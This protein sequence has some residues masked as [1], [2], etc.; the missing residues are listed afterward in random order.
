MADNLRI[1]GKPLQT[2]FQHVNGSTCLACP[3]RKRPILRLIAAKFSHKQPAAS[4]HTETLTA[5]HALTGRS[6][7]SGADTF[8]WFRVRLLAEH[9]PLPRCNTALYC[10]C[11]RKFECL[12]SGVLASQQILGTWPG[13][14]HQGVQKQPCIGPRASAMLS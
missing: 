6:Q 5:E 3:R 14:L 11:R 8:R 2:S 13:K 12:L 1:F 10:L 7:R 9:L 4:T